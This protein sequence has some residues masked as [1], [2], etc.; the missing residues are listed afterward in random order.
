MLYSRLGLVRI[1]SF[2]SVKGQVVVYLL[3]NNE[4][5]FLYAQPIDLYVYAP[6]ARNPN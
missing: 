5:D 2:Y 4:P 3:L 1:N 6:N